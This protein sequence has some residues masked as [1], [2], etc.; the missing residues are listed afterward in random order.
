[1][2]GRLEPQLPLW[3]HK[4]G[5]AFKL[6]AGLGSRLGLGLALTGRD[7]EERSVSYVWNDTFALACA[8]WYDTRWE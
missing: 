5:M 6:H 3:P 1:M 2:E 4:R 7:L 8:T